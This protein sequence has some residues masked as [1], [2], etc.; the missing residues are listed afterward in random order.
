M[1]STPTAL[2]LKL[3]A[4]EGKGGNGALEDGAHLVPN[5]GSTGTAGDWSKQPLPIDWRLISA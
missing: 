3:A 1:R 2:P 5:G 4:R